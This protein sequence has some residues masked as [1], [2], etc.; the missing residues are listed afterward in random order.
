MEPTIHVVVSCSNSKTLPVPPEVQFRNIRKDP[1]NRSFAAWSQAL[2]E[3]D[4]QRI[5]AWQLYK[6]D[7]WAVTKD[8]M[9]LGSTRTVRVWVCSA[10]YGLIDS[11]QEIKPYAATFSSSQPDSIAKG[12]AQLREW[13]EQQVRWRPQGNSGPRSFEEAM[14]LYPKDRWLVTLSPPYLQAVHLDLSHGRLQLESPGQLS[15]LSTGTSRLNGLSDALLPADERL[16]TLLS[17]AKLSLNV[18]IAR[19]LLREVQDFNHQALEGFILENLSRLERPQRPER[20][21]MSDDEI[22]QFVRTQLLECSK[23]SHTALLR[24]LRLQGKACEQS[25]FARLFRQV[26]N[27]AQSA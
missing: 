12:S 2:D 24:L 7:H 21:V 22:V 8:I 17:G 11:S 18:R 27:E 20:A 3:L 19:W 25:R 13:W 10:G 6:G 1:P 9:A 4:V 16:Q 23:F 5:P 15:V 14:T 26:R